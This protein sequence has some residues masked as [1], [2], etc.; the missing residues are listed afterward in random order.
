MLDGFIGVTRDGISGRKTSGDARHRSH[1]LEA[2][3]IVEVELPPG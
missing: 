1:A 2:A 3:I